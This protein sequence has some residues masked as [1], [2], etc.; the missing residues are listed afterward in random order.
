[1]T[2]NTAPSLRDL[3]F[4][5]EAASVIDD[6]AA[7]DAFLPELPDALECHA[8][9]LERLPPLLDLHGRAL[10][11]TQQYERFLALAEADPS[12]LDDIGNALAL[13]AHAGGIAMLLVPPGSAEDRFAKAMLTKERGKQ[14]HDGCGVHDAELMRRALRQSF[15]DSNP[16]LVI[17]ARIPPGTEEAARRFSGAVLPQSHESDADA[18]GVYHLEQG[19]ALDEWFNAPPELALL[20]DEARV[21]FETIETSSQAEP[22]SFSWYGARRGALI[23]AYAKLCRVGLWPARSSSDLIA[24]TEVERLISER[25][26][27]PDA[28][29][30][31]VEIA[32][33]VGRRIARQ[34]GRFVTVLGGVEL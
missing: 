31:L 28:M 1:M 13:L 24:K 22:P 11:H 34:G 5:T 8:A 6:L 7:L 2:D 14:Y 27:D 33:R 29:R 15:A 4:T 18:P 12:A 32:L 21:L 23:L 20:L 25:G 16:R 3:V 26:T 30:A 9:L 19:L 10:V 17:G